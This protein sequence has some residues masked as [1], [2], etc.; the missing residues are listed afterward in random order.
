M[1]AYI[2]IYA[3]FYV[4]QI[5]DCVGEVIKKTKR[6]TTSLP[7]KLIPDHLR[8]FSFSPVLGIVLYLRQKYGDETNW[9]G[10]VC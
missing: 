7:Y 1:V 9:I 10:Y 4:F 8:L 6:Q 2:F 5:V 3:V